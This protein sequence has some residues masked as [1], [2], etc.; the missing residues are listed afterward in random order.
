MNKKLISL[1]VV[2]SLVIPVFA[3][4]FIDISGHWAETTII[5]LYEQNIV[6]GVSKITAKPD[7]PL[8]AYEWKTMVSRLMEKE[9]N[10]LYSETLMTREDAIA[11]LY[12][13]SK[14]VS[15]KNFELTYTDS[16]EINVG[17]V[18]AVKWATS[19]DLVKGNALGEFMPKRHLTRA[20][21]MT[22]VERYMSLSLGDDDSSN[23][24]NNAPTVEHAD[25]ISTSI[26]SVSDTHYELT[27]SMGEKST[28]GYSIQIVDY[29]IVGD[30]VI[31]TVKTHTPSAGDAV[32]EALTYPKDVMIIPKDGLS[33]H[34]SVTIVEQ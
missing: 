8:K 2:L 16:G 25:S 13:Q 10:F 28:G 15:S 33:N 4:D 34:P 9:R 24:D 18:D 31:V 3:H 21:A 23:M 7:Q 27:V 22:I 20:E 11:Y 17:N 30:S 6:K 19:T 1:I 5:N 14:A 29:K 32:T 26:T 12:S